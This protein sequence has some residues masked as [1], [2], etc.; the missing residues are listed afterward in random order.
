MPV[1]THSHTAV[2]ADWLRKRHASIKDCEVKAWKALHEDKDEKAY[3]ALMAERTDRIASLDEES[4][5]LTAVLP[6]DK[7]EPIE[8]A[9]RRFARGARNA[10]RLES[11]F[12]MSALLYPDEHREGEPD[13]L[14][15][16]L[17]ELEE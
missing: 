12:Y 9:L 13:N 17:Q 15:R 3:R 5:E 11:V 4:A 16:L 8:T 2:L 14:E 10:Q 6:E 7:R 1:S